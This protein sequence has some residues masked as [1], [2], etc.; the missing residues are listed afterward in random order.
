[1]LLS[2]NGAVGGGLLSFLILALRSCGVSG[3]EIGI[4]VVL[5]S[6]S[7]YEFELAA[8]LKLFWKIRCVPCFVSADS[9]RITCVR[10]IV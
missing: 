5:G 7:E 4:G 3:E 6:K 1:M 2:E 10:K 9:T 8:I